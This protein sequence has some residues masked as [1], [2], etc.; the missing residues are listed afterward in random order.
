MVNNHFI[1]RIG[2]DLSNIRLGGGITHIRELLQNVDLNAHAIDKV[3]LWGS[4]STLNQLPK[5]DWLEKCNPIF[6]EQGLFLRI[7]WQTFFLSSAAK[8]KGCSVLFIPGGSFL[9]KFSPVVVM[10]QN[11]IPFESREIRR[12]GISLRSLKFLALRVIQGMSF[13]RAQGVIFLTQYAR[14]ITTKVVGRMKGAQIAVI[15]HGLSAMFCRSKLR[16]FEGSEAD[17]S[18]TS[19]EIIYV[20]NIDLYKH[21][22]QVL[23]AIALLR[24][25]GNSIKIKFIGPSVKCAMSRLAKLIKLYDP[26][27]DW[28]TYGGVVN[29]VDM[30]SI[31]K[32]SDIAV[33]AS[34]CE[35]FGITLL[36]KM[37][38][39]LP[40]ACSDSSCM[41][42]ILRDGG[43]Y[44][45]PEDFV[46]IA[47]AIEKY[48][49]SDELRMEKSK[50]GSQLAGAYSWKVCAK[51]TFAFLEKVALDANK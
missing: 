6:L 14:Q 9:G 43:L 17:I 11:L 5:Y 36:E 30:P 7:I 40:I 8:K 20:S 21:Q 46:S 47:E 22:D 23:K 16:N 2:I 4:E 12:F 48:L 38:S 15:P 1:Q 3:I 10:S 32:N 25:K 34:T 35:T 44:F 51:N 50:R 45:N 19:Y 29:Y 39:G 31:Y 26:S 33:F 42:E 37:A 28:A 27:G 18:R 24:S 49:C 13:R 41:P